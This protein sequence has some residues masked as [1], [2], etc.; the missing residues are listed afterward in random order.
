[1]HPLISSHLKGADKENFEAY[2][3]NSKAILE[4]L[5]FLVE[6]K[7]KASNTQKV[8]EDS[9][10]SPSWA[11]KQADHN[12]YVRALEDVLKLFELGDNGKP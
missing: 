1:M 12:G 4:R 7:I 2:F 5:H 8:S 10:D 6:Q 3:R 9:Y 11:Y